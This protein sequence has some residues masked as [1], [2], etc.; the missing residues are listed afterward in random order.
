MNYCNNIING[1]YVRDLDL[2]RAM[3]RC[4]LENRLLGLDFPCVEYFSRVRAENG[5]ANGT[6]QEQCKTQAQDNDLAYTLCMTESYSPSV[7]PLSTGYSCID[8]VSGECVPD[9]SYR[10]CRDICSK[11]PYCN[12]GYY[13]HDSKLCV[14]L[15]TEL[16]PL[17]GF[18]DQGIDLKKIDAY[19][20]WR[21]DSFYDRS[22]YTDIPTAVVYN[23]D[24]IE[25][26]HKDRVLCRDL[27]FR[28]N[29]DALR[30][31]IVHYPNNI[32]IEDHTPVKNGSLVSLALAGSY[33]TLS[34]RD[35][36]FRIMTDI[37][38]YRSIH[39]LIQYNNIFIIR[40]DRSFITEDRPSFLSIV[41]DEK[42]YPVGMNN[43][44]RLDRASHSIG[45]HMRKVGDSP[46]P[47]L[48]R[49]YDE[50]AKNLLL[51]NK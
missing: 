22:V 31:R 29:G 35:G 21:V 42:V 10:K 15:A 18:P 8:T 27:V 4:V 2:D 30:M 1:V 44:Y 50:Y 5:Y 49:E 17:R 24:T 46:V 37:N 23:A 20:N 25:L 6:T 45:F 9:V 19:K 16:R 48:Y 12:A 33:T 26:W 13:L 41:V 14:P 43:Q 39:A 34:Y 7:V 28:K 38:I 36:R 11:N 40:G 3:E 32:L 47:S 51:Q